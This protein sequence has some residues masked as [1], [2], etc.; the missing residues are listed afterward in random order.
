MNLNPSFSIFFDNFP[1]PNKPDFPFPA[2][3]AISLAY[4]FIPYPVEPD[5]PDWYD[6]DLEEGLEQCL[7]A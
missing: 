1:F 6:L 2:S 4:L 3:L 7:D 5:F